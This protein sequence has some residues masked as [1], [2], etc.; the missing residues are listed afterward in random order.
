MVTVLLGATGVLLVVAVLLS[1]GGM[2]N[3]LEEKEIEKLRK[4]IALLEAAE[5]ELRAVRN[6]SLPDSASPGPV[7]TSSP[8]G[9]ASLEAE[10]AEKSETISRLEDNLA[11]AE[12][13]ART[14]NKEAELALDRTID[15]RDRQKKRARIINEATLMG[16]VT[17]WSAA[18][19]FAVIEILRPDL[20]DAGTVLAIRRNSGIAGQLRISRMY[21]AGQAVADPVTASFLGD[22]VDVQPGD[23]LIIDPQ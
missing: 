17:E 22:G 8:P 10:L 2:R 20:V 1:F 15:Q 12:R 6:Q 7:S 19:G 14:S 4:E 11:E 21:E 13:E 23:E 5:D 3:N 9:L 16:R 18:N